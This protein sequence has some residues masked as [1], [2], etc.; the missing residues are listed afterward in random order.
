MTAPDIARLDRIEATQREIL[1][2][3]ARL[4]TMM[5]APSPQDPLVTA[6]AAEFGKSL[7]TSSDA[8]ARA[9]KLAFEA[10]NLGREP[11]GLPAALAEKGIRNAHG[12][13]RWAVKH[14]RPEMQDRAG[15]LWVAISKPHETA[16]TLR[17]APPER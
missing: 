10:R 16:R 11:G 15:T 12:F 1:H 3:L 17:P 14:L 2:A 9:E 7:F 8:L 4:E 13:G 6:L 5:T